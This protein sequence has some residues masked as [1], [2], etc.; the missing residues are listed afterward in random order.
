M[1]GGAH[2]YVLVVDGREIELSDGEVTLG[3]SRSC[4]VRVDHES[5]SRSHALVTL[6]NGTAILKD[7]N[8]SNGTFVAGRR[9]LS[10]TVLRSGDR[11]QIGAA[12]LEYRLL[13][14]SGPIE[15][16]AL[17]T[18]SAAEVLPGSPEADAGPPAPARP[19]PLEISAA[20]LFR[21]VDGFG[22][23]RSLST[24]SCS[25]WPSCRRGPAGRS[26]TSRRPR[27]PPGTPG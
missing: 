5:V 27:W 6:A 11:V 22:R 10:E 14:P 7:L 12:V 13:E 8:S 24:R 23:Q 20:D 26:A 1:P 4:T 25:A 21:G 15:K 17:L 19:S 2:R 9:I 16:T 18:P 3:R